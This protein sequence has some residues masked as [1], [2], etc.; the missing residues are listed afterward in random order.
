MGRGWCTGAVQTID[1]GTDLFWAIDPGETKCGVAIF[2]HGR[3]VQ[4][5]A[6]TPDECL[7]KLWEHLG[8]DLAGPTRPRGV[9]LETFAL[10]ADLAAQQTGSEMGTSQMIGAVRWMCRHREAPLVMQTPRQAHSI[11]ENPGTEPFRSWPLRRW[12]SYGQGRDAKMAERHGLFRVSTSWETR[13]QR[14]AWRVSMS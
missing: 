9:V 13:E 4:A 7:D 3:C 12:A 5:L 1:W 11:D 2:Q 14:E 8:Y 10:R 6:S